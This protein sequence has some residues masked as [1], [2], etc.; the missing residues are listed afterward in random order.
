MS[1]N[2]CRLYRPTDIVT[3]VSFGRCLR[4]RQAPLGLPSF[5][6]RFAVS[7][8]LGPLTVAE[9]RRSKPSENCRGS[10]SAVDCRA[11]YNNNDAL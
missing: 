1:L 11:R 7:P 5:N 4:A 6:D 8:E 10:L 3:A 9:K 2:R